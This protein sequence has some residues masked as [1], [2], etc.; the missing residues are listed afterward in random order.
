[1]AWGGPGWPIEIRSDGKR[2]MNDRQKRC[3]FLWMV[4]SGSCSGHIILL[5]ILSYSFPDG[6]ELC[7]DM[8]G[9]CC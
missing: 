5:V 4:V 6:G 3:V 8:A 7:D 2:N 1:M 9:S